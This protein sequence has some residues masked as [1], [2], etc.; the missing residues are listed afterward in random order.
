MIAL[1]TL[2][3]NLGE[4]LDFGEFS[5]LLKNEGIEEKEFKVDLKN[6]RITIGKN[7]K[8]YKDYYTIGN[9][10]Y[11]KSIF[12]NRN[13]LLMLDEVQDMVDKGEAY[14]NTTQLLLLLA[15]WKKINLVI[16]TATPPA[17]MNSYIQKE[18]DEG[19]AHIESQ[20]LQQKIESGIGGRIDVEVC[21]NLENSE[22]VNKYVEYHN[23]ALLKRL[24]NEQ[25]YYNHKEDESSTIEQKVRKYIMWNV[26]SVRNRMTLA[27]M[28]S[29][30]A[31]NKLKEC[32]WRNKKSS[33]IGA[34]L[35]ESK[36][37]D[38]TNEVKKE[39]LG[40]FGKENTQVI[41]EVLE[42]FEYK[43]SI[44]DSGTFAVLHGV[45]N[46]VIACIIHDERDKG[47]LEDRLSD[48]NNQRFLN[49]ESF[50]EK[51]KG[52]IANLDNQAA[53]YKINKHV[54]DLDIGDYRNREY[55]ECTMRAVWRVLKDSNEE[56]LII[57]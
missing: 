16:T 20:S 11:E 15:H 52:T 1:E 4:I 28:D 39:L 45:I 35:K 33:E 27:C 5:R 43:G 47:T 31:Q 34:F 6:E 50:R 22:F 41:N 55:V 51:V 49:I 12:S 30:N 48:L 7:V 57:R 42:G 17:W 18:K 8:I 46:N 44:V 14:Y 40:Q 19:R 56:R 10:K 2:L 13:L 25:Y 32:L 38:S 54:Q 37:H 9:K 26:Q 3:N 23:Q 29:T 24:E 36:S 53:Y 21:H